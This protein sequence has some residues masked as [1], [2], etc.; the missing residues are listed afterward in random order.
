MREHWLK[1]FHIIRRTITK[2][3]GAHEDVL[4][5]LHRALL[6]SRVVCGYNYVRVNSRA[7]ETLE[8]LNRKTMRLITGL[9]A[10]TS[11]K[12]L[13]EWARIQRFEHTTEERRASQVARLQLTEMGRGILRHLI[14]TLPTPPP[15]ATLPPLWEHVDV[16]DM[17]AALVPDGKVTPE[18]SAA[19][20]RAHVKE[21]V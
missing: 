7:R 5:T 6:E 21:L 14:P 11:I 16:V 12:H 1:A 19:W 2:S 8:V 9:P 13:E 20:N 18:K 10:F 17:A 15:P 4:R 3:W